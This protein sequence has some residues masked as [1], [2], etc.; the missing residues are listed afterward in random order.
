M[1]DII[2]LETW[3]KQHQRSL[4]FRK[5][6]DPYFI[7][8]SEIMLQQTQV[9]TVIP[10]FK[11]FIKKYPTIKSLANTDEETLFS[12]IQG[13]GYY[14]RF[15][16]ML[17]AANTV[18][19]EHN[20][21]F[22]NTYQEIRKL[23][24]IGEYT[25]GA[26]MS[27]AYNKPY[28]ATDGNVIRVIARTYD[29]E[30]DMRIEKNKKKIK[31]IN[32]K[33]VEDSRPEI[34]TQ[35]LMEL[36]A[37][38]CR[39]LNPDCKICPLKENCMAFLLNKQN[40]LPYLSK[41]KDKKTIHF[42]VFMVQTD[43]CIYLRKRTEKLLGGMYEFPQYEKGETIP[44]NFKIIEEVGHFKHVFTHLVWEMNVLRVVL[45]SNPLEDWIKINKTDIENYPMATAHKKIVNHKG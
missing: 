6:K 26:I 14:R 20:D 24:G 21:V 29:I 8:V 23:A 36:G 5:S 28:A 38:I 7:W 35:A 9:E 33:L 34:F 11:K 31:L 12:V 40:D 19:E 32:Q 30:D 4:P 25:A 41:K 44:F 22:P 27:I 2:Q 3:Y 17:K 15:K 13:L 16:N 45:T 42:N 1:I 43:Q 10:Y 18:H 37:T 39:P